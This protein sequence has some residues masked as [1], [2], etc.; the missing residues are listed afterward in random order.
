MRK[1]RETKK[2]KSRVRLLDRGTLATFIRRERIKQESRGIRRH[3]LH[4]EL[5]GARVKDLVKRRPFML[6]HALTK[7]REKAQPPPLNV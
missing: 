7:A 2:E 1:K 4:C 6:S 3:L 5:A